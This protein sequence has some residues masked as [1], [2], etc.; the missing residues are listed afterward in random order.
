LN[1]IAIAQNTQYAIKVV[2]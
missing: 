1:I 2:Q